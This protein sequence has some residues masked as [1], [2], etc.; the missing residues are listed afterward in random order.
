MTADPSEI[1]LA[2]KDSRLNSLTL[3][4]FDSPILKMKMEEF[5]FSNPP[6]DPE[7]LKL[8]L[9]SAM[10]RMGGVGLSANQVGLPFRVFAYGT[11]TDYVVAFN[12]KIVG[13]SRETILLKE[14]CLSLPNIWLMIKRPEV[15]VVSYQQSNGEEVKVQLKGLSSRIFQHEYDHMEGRNFTQLASPLKLKRALQHLKKVNRNGKRK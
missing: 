12:P 15:V 11:N 7:E 2:Y 5:D 3:L 14:G 1:V 9:A 13:Y 8:A 4:L 10:V 6:I